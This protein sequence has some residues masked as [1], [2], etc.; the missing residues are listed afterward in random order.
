MLTFLI[1]TNNKE[2]YLNRALNSLY[3]QTNK[4]FKVI[5]S[6]SSENDYDNLDLN[7]NLIDI[8][9]Y[10]NKNFHIGQSYN[11][12]L[13]Q[14][15]Q[16]DYYM[17][18]EDDDIIL[19]DSFIDDV[20]KILLDYNPDLLITN[21]ISSLDL[22]LKSCYLNKENIQVNEIDLNLSDFNSKFQI[23]QIIFK[24]NLIA[25]I[26][27]EEY[28]YNTFIGY[29][30]LLSILNKYNINN[31]FETNLISIISMMNNYW[32]S[33]SNILKYS[34]ILCLEYFKNNNIKISD[35]FILDNLKELDL[36]ISDLYM[37]HPPMLN[38]NNKFLNNLSYKSWA[39][40]KEELFLDLN[41]LN[42]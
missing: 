37:L 16:T 8:E 18:L 22:G 31:I 41:K 42:K 3:K 24:S 26:N 17:M 10:H 2:E 25:S 36:N 4:D 39:Q 21:Y 40:A 38:I 13:T 28:G 5:I 6:N 30:Y 14:K 32:D 20:N 27:I 7:T 19:N 23:S 35:K 11:F 33:N 15:I 34:L 29:M 12:L 1:Q 9:Y